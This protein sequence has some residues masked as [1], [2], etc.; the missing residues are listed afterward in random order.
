MYLTPFVSVFREQGLQETRVFITRGHAGLPDDTYA[1]ME[2]YCTDPACDCRRVMLNVIGQHQ[3]PTPLA[4]VS[5]AFDRDAE[6][7]GPFLDPLNPRSQHADILFP[8]VVQIL[9]DP[10]YVARLESHYHQIKRRRRRSTRPGPLLVVQRRRGAGR[11]PLARALP[12]AA[13]WPGAEHGPPRLSG[14]QPAFLG[15]VGQS[16]IVQEGPRRAE[17]GAGADNLPP[18]PLTPR[19]SP[20]WERRASHQYVGLSPLSHD[21]SYPLSTSRQGGPERDEGRSVRNRQVAR[22]H[23]V[24][25]LVMRHIRRGGVSPGFRS[26]GGWPGHGAGRT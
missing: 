7:A 1:L 4:S 14:V 16:E 13:T 8:L 24:A 11:A 9:A 15:L 26:E 23:V 21:E 19:P 20:I 3:G 12:C 10:A 25:S 5:F 2:A 18:H 17:T 6:M 22:I